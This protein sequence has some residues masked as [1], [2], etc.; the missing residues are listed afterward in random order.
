MSEVLTD[1]FSLHSFSCHFDTKV[2]NEGL[3]EYG[4]CYPII[5]NL[6]LCSKLVV[7]SNGVSYH[8]LNNVCTQFSDS[9]RLIE[10]NR[11][12]RKAFSNQLPTFGYDRYDMEKRGVIYADVARD[13]DIYYSPHPN[14][15][16]EFSEK[17]MQCVNRTAISVINQYDQR[18]S[19]SAS[20]IV[21]NINIKIP[22]VVEHV[23]YLSKTKNITISDS[24]NYIRNSK[25]ATR[26]R[27]Y[28]DSLD[29]ELR[30]LT[31]RKKLPIYQR[32]FRE[33]DS[34]SNTWLLDMDEEVKYR[35]RRINLTKLPIAGKVFETV[36]IGNLSIPDPIIFPSSPHLLFINDLYNK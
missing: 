6:V 33:I 35:T 31:P 14:R 9:I 3:E 13:Y 19:E 1:L 22:P 16:I 32:L 5:E 29:D 34:L 28:F 26:F 18:F 2:K 7:D 27:K 20:G 8:Q 11:L 15:Q 23:F 4:E 25:N 21:S 12:Y 24:I 30:D 36:G 10:D 17:I